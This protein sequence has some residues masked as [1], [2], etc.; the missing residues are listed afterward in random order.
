MSPEPTMRFGQ[1]ALMVDLSEREAF[2]A[3]RLFLDAFYERAGD[4]LDTLRADLSIEADGEPLDPAAWQDWLAAV[5]SVK[6]QD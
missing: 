5:R 2:E 6:A 1:D 3:M 4:D